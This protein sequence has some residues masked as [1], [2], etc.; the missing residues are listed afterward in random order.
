MTE[1]KA[2]PDALK[3]KHHFLILDGLRGVAALAVV[4]FHFMEWVFTDPSTNFIGHGFLAVDFF[5]CL[6][7]F[8]IGYA[9]DDRIGKMGIA[10]FFKARLIR[11]HPLV[12]LGSVLGLLGFFLDPFASPI[13]FDT[14]KVALLFICSLLL[15][16]FPVMGERFFNLFAFNAP[17]WSLFWEYVANAFY[18]LFLYKVSRR[19]LTALTILAAAGICVVSY[20]AGNLLGGWSKDNFLDGGARVA[21]SFLAGLLIYRSNWISKNSLGFAGLSVLLFLAF[22]MPW[23]RLDWLMEVLIVLLYFPLMVSLGAGSS[24][25]PRWEKVCKFSGNISYPLYMTHY[26]G[27]WIF[28]NYFTNRKPQSG[29]LILIIIGGVVFLVVFAYLAMVLYDVPVRK[30]LARKRIQGKSSSEV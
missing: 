30:Y 25:S 13:D 12:V 4:I 10:E 15:I 17:S 14:G 11:L 23:S 27:I 22:I 1:V 20:R 18:A 21:Y 24:I 8:V 6:S 26:A 5:F 2:G 28:G 9:Y 3:A 7:G 19:L 16:P 29:E